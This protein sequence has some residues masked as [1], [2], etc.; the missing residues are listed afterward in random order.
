MGIVTEWLVS[1]SAA[2]AQANGTFCFN[3]S[4]QGVKYLE[5][6]GYFDGAVLQYPE[7]GFFMVTHGEVL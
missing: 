6:T 2:S 5:I 4:S 7:R 3:L 1:G